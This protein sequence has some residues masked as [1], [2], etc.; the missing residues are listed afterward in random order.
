VRA[1]TSGKSEQGRIHVQPAF[2]SSGEHAS[3]FPLR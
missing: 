3:G 1:R 2:C